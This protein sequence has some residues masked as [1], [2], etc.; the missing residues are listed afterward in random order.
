MVVEHVHM[1]WAVVESTLSVAIPLDTAALRV[2]PCTITAGSFASEQV[3]ARR[4]P[5][6]RTKRRERRII[7]RLR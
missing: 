4:R 1:I 7:V 5:R 6:A 2:V 3:C